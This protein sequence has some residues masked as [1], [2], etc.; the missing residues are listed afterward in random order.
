MKATTH[1]LAAAATLA[2]CL[3]GV[4]GQ[5]SRGNAL[6]PATSD[7]K[8]IMRASLNRPGA[9]RTM[10]RVKM[11]IKDNSGTRERL[12]SMRSLRW[13]DG[14]KTLLLIESPQDVRNT[15]FLSI[16]YRAS[17]RSDEQWLYLPNLHR[18]TRVPS[19]GRSD[20]FMG[21]DFSYADLSQQDPDDYDLRLV[22]GSE[23]VGDED[24]WLIEGVPR[25]AALKEQTGYSK[26]Q[27]WLSKSKLVPLQMKAWLTKD[28]KVKYFKATDLKEIDGL[29]TPQRLQMRTLRGS[30]VL[31][32]T[33]LEMLLIKNNSPEIVDA[34]FTQQRLER[35]L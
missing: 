7:P 28:E 24:C 14:R 13:A 32:E 8:V 34:D 27:T 18:I 17:D 12:V 26:M 6:D 2:L 21:S 19:S 22:S 16:D 20:A 33:L 3:L 29:W 15:G 1:P 23:R 10:S 30:T 11:T 5:P 35:G 4:L 9:D 25:T 31:S